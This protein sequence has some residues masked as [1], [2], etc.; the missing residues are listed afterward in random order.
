MMSDFNKFT[1]VCFIAVVFGSGLGI[2]H[3]IRK[4]ETEID[5]S[6]KHLVLIEDLQTANK[7]F[8]KYITDKEME[9]P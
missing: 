4:L 6:R 8:H 3:L 7:A 5:K 9:R 2:I 1:V